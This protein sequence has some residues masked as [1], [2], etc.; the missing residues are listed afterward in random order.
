VSP[1]WGSR[2]RLY[3]VAPLGLRFEGRETLPRWRTTA[4]LHGFVQGKLRKCQALL[5]PR[6]RSLAEGAETIGGPARTRGLEGAGHGSRGGGVEV[7]RMTLAL[8][9]SSFCSKKHQILER[10]SASTV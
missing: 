8:R 10:V 5:G 7:M 6:V 2:P 9:L 3:A 1:T 4:C